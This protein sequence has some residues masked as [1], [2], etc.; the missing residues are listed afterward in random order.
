MKIQNELDTSSLPSEEDDFDSV[1]SLIDSTVPYVIPEPDR[2]VGF[3]IDSV[4]MLI[5][6]E[7][8]SRATE[9]LHKILELL[10]L[11][12]GDNCLVD[13]VW[14]VDSLICLVEAALEFKKPNPQLDAINKLLQE[15]RAKVE[16]FRKPD[17][18]P[19]LRQ[20]PLSDSLEI[21]VHTGGNIERAH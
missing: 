16:E 11:C 9:E 1:A 3:V 18:G 8:N 2:H 5:R 7:S 21:T 19:D 4:M 20:P 17:E 15:A 13:E 10:M 14:R 12:S 6:G